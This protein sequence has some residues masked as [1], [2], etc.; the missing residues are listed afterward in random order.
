LNDSFV[1]F[2][3]RTLFIVTAICGVVLWMLIGEPD[4]IGMAAICVIYCLMP[5]VTIAGIVFH[6]GYWQAFF[7]GM[8]RW[9]VAMTFTMVLP[10]P[11]YR[12]F[13]TQPV[14]L[15]PPFLDFLAGTD[16]VLRRKVAVLAAALR[17]LLSQ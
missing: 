5:A 17:A 7:I 3:F 12:G 13:G 1:Q 4:L 8:A 14:F 2:Q 16:Q 11:Q 9:V 10:G 15:D 6:R